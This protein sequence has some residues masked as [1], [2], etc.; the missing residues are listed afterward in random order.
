MILPVIMLAVVFTQ[1]KIQ[2]NNTTVLNFAVQKSLK[3]NFNNS[4]KY[5]KT[6]N[7]ANNGA[8]EFCMKTYIQQKSIADYN[9]LMKILNYCGATTKTEYD[10]W[11]CISAKM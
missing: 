5:C 7:I 1:Q 6:K 10:K 8:F 3:I 2:A 4:I 11:V 9:T